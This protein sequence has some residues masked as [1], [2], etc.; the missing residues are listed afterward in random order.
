MEAEQSRAWGWDCRPGHEGAGVQE[1]Q[2]RAQGAGKGVSHGGPH[3]LRNDAQEQQERYKDAA[4]ELTESE[5]R[6]E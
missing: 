1:H 2:G 6:M 5:K 4:K 3:C